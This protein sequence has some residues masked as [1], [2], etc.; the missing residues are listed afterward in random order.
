MLAYIV[1]DE[2]GIQVP[3]QSLKADGIREDGKV[4]TIVEVEEA[5]SVLRL[6]PMWGTCLVY[7][8]VFSQS[9]TFFTKLGATMNRTIIPGFNISAA[10]L[11]SVIALAILVISRL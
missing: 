1:F 7:S 10:S 11:Q 8:I 3:S 5:K 9:S 4:S 2:I 6:V